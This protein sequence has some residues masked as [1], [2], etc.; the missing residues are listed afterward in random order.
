VSKRSYKKISL[1][2]LER[3]IMWILEEAGEETLCTVL[4]TLWPKLS[5]KLSADECLKEF[6][7]AVRALK[8]RGL[9]FLGEDKGASGAAILPLPVALQDEVLSSIENDGI[10]DS[11]TGLWSL[12][13]SSSER[14][15]RLVLTDDGRDA[16]TR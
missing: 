1:S 12:S 8:G 9:I 16:L 10:L 11:T 3:D 15:I 7:D 13:G 2:T 4:N 6:K 14:S 5:A